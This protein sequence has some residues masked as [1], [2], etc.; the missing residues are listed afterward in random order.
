L[1]SAHVP[2]DVRIFVKECQTLAAAGYEVHLIAP[3]ADDG[4]RN[5]VRVHDV[6]PR[7]DENRLARM[8]STV[9]AVYRR[10]RALA[11]DLYHFHDPELLPAGLR[12]A[13]SGAAVVY[14]VHE[15]YAATIVNRE[16]IRP[17]LRRPVARVIGR[18]EPAA[19]NRLAAVVAATPAVAERFSG[20]RCEV[21]TV[22]NF[23]DLREFHRVPRRQSP[24]EAAVCYVGSI[25][26]M[27]G[28]EVMVDAVAR[29]EARLLLAGSFDSA[30]FHERLRASPGWSQ[31][32]YLG[33][34]DR[35]AVAEIF[36]RSCAGLVLLRPSAQY[37]R[38]HPTKM[39][40]YMSAGLPVIASDFPLWRE[41]VE[42][43]GCGLCV[44]PLSPDAVADAIRWI[45]THPEEAL[46]MGENGRCAVAST[47]NWLPEGEKLVA[48]YGRLLESGRG[49]RNRERA[50]AR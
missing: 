17:R 36:E 50:K 40:E 7:R 42:G 41:F 11:A 12:L 4:V 45:V 13:R 15:D 20:C 5:G 49:R 9:L 6:G 1:T 16:W 48:L 23:P 26:P 31:V 39:F 43:A 34:A 25:F 21:V 32:E 18:V 24:A 19:A 2:S 46:E 33:H 47:Y 10:A 8:T 37:L 22:N 35:G 30:A 14:D 27:R 3:G 28:I 44:D 29:T 38:S